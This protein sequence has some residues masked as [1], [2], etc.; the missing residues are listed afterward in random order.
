MN[1]TNNN[2]ETPK[3]APMYLNHVQLIG[4]LGDKPTHY[5]NRAIFSL[6]TKTSWKPKDSDEWQHITE[7]HR[8]VAWDDVAEA[9]KPLAKGDYLC[10]DGALRSSTY[11]KEVGLGVDVVSVP[12]TAWEI[13]V[14]AVRK[15]AHKKKPAAKNA[16]AEPLKA[17]A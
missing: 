1:K 16:K 2:P 12:I 11:H 10:I 15:L 17:A 7:W 5:E 14:R 6:A 3:A 8:C 4:F 9:I 13:R